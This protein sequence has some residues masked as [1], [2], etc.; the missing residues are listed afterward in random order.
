VLTYIKKI[1]PTSKSPREGGGGG[2]GG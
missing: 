1:I 2:G